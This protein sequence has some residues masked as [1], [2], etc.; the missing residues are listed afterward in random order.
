MTTL[1]EPAA[2][3]LPPFLEAAEG[4]CDA[5]HDALLEQAATLLEQ[6]CVHLPDRRAQGVDPVARLRHLRSCLPDRRSELYRELLAVFAE[7]GDQ[8]TQCYLPEPLASHVAFLPFVVRDFTEDGE[9]RLAVV[10]SAVDALRRGDL[11]LTWNGLPAE[12]A[13]EEHMALQL[14]AHR[15]ARR[16]KALQTLTFRPLA[17][18]PPPPEETVRVEVAGAQGRRREARLAWQ[19]AS[20]EWLKEHLTPALGEEA[21]PGGPIRAGRVE[22]SRG[23]FGHLRVASFD[24]SPEPFLAAFLAALAE[25]PPEGMILDLRGSEK[26]FIQTGEQLLQLFTPD[27]IEP[28]RFQFRMTPLIERLVRTC[29]ALQGWRDAVE[30][31]G[32]CGEEYS[33]GRPLTPPDEANRMGRRYRGPVVLLVDALTYSTAEMVAA[34]FQDHGIGP[35]LGTGGRTGGGGGS[36]WT[37]ST[38]FKLSGD[39]TLRPLPQ[40]PQLRVAVLRCRRTGDRAGQM[41]EGV[42]VV[43]D[44]VHRPTRADRLEGSPDLMEAAGRWLAEQGH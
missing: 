15:E 4:P 32:R 23:V 1:T 5:E 28:L 25:M 12:R 16:E 24:A 6:A 22:T 26:G 36:P 10:S 14:C 30:T 37:Q 34:G 42:G 44:E 3:F 29:P 9:R 8:H 17:W 7:L 2:G 31:A 18:L 21:A 27:K 20:S 13:L 11:L 35:V 39:E 38:I 19:V 41:L 43:P 40:A 33:R